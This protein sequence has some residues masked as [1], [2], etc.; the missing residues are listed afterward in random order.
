MYALFDLIYVYIFL[1]KKFQCSSLIHNILV[2][3]NNVYVGTNFLMHLN[4]ESVSLKKHIDD[5]VFKSSNKW[6]LV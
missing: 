6:P 5:L 3:E 4:F 2:K 1:Y